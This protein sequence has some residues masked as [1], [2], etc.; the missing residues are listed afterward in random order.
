MNLIHCIVLAALLVFTIALGI[1]DAN[2]GVY[3]DA[4]GLDGA[5]VGWF[6]PFGVPLMGLAVLV[7]LAYGFYV[8]DRLSKKS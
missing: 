5:K 4:H 2:S 6:A 8:I 3:A 1:N 7:T